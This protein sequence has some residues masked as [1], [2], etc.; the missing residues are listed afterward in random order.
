MKQLFSSVLLITT[1]LGAQASAS[2]LICGN[3]FGTSSSTRLI[4]KPPFEQWLIWEQEANFAEFRKDRRPIKVDFSLVS[5][6]G[7][8]TT[9][10]PDASTKLKEFIISGNKIRWFKHP[11]NTVESLPDAQ[12][13][14]HG[15]VKAYLTASRSL[16]LKVGDEFYTI[17]MPTDYPHG[18]KGQYQP[19]KASTSED[20]LDGINRMN[21][22]SR[23]DS[24]IGLDPNLI[25]AKE[26]AMVADKKTGEGF[27]F[28][29]LSFMKSGNYYLPALSIPYIGR[30]I[31]EKNGVSVEEFWQ[32][33]YAELLGRSKAKLLLR[34]GAQMETPNSQN[35]LIELDKN[36]KPTGR[37][38]FRDIS[39]TVLIEG[40][41]TG[42]GEAGILKKDSENGVENSEIIQPYWSNSAWRFDEAGDKS[43]SKKT[44]IQ[45]GHAHNM[46]YLKEIESALG[47]DLSLFQHII[48]SRS[49]A[50]EE[51]DEFDQ[52]MAS[53]MVRNKL[54]AY[55]LKE[56]VKHQTA[57][58]QNRFAS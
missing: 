36:L 29:D 26:V 57:L 2:P 10:L 24:E 9:F 34:Y 47:L 11:Y 50:V 52:F 16:A 40:V 31:A 12:E 8:E 51:A 28:R 7:I 44:L 30:E 23:V 54:K 35:M 55:R 45:W 3:I 48:K 4:E 14:S 13:V 33:A 38:V 25:L 1:L 39:D 41:A 27:L 58:R 49:G 20:I 37:L 5:Q 56:K 46:A 6:K 15:N 32:K 53:P 19:G 43:F 21:Y 42:L 17:K 22:F 18:P